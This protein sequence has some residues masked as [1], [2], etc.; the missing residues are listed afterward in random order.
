MIT[1]VRLGLARWGVY[2]NDRLI[3][4]YTGIDYQTIARLWFQLGVPLDF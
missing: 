1:I 3:G 2:I 4:G